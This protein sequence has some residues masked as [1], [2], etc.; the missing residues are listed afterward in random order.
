MDVYILNRPAHIHFHLSAALRWF[1]GVRLL[2]NRLHEYSLLVLVQAGVGERAGRVVHQDPA[3]ELRDKAEGAWRQLRR[4]Q[5]C[6]HPLE[7]RR[8]ACA[9]RKPASHM[10][11]GLPRL[12]M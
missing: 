5:H 4:S 6:V 8:Q 3:R 7:E 2:L 10:R 11:P 12:F 9:G 1:D